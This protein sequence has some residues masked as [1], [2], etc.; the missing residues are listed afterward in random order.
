MDIGVYLR[1]GLG[2]RLFLAAA[3][4][5]QAAVTGRAPRIVGAEPSA[6]SGSAYLDTVFADFPQGAFSGPYAEVRER[7]NR[8]L[9]YDPV[10]P[11]PGAGSLLLYGYFQHERY[12]EGGKD[13]FVRTLRLPVAPTLPGTLFVHVRRGDYL[14]VPMHNVD[15]TRYN[16]RAVDLARATFGARLTTVL[17]FSN[18]P[19]W[20]RAHVAFEGLTTVVAD[21]PDEVSTLARMAACELGGVCA[22]SSFSWWGAF[23]GYAPGKLVTFP[24]VWF[25]RVPDPGSAAE[26]ADDVAFAGS[27]RVAVR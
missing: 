21:E 25:T 7:P 6:H 15:L 22:N 2:N 11:A 10:R 19:A 26:F 9:C 3:A 18:D 13:A 23:L 12:L 24:D 5:G 17:V 1:G 14:E 4:F 16:A 8:C 27:V 20:C